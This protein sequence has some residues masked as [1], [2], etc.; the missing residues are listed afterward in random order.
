MSYTT[1][2]NKKRQKR[3]KYAWAAAM[4]GAYMSIVSLALLLIVI[5][6]YNE[7][8][9]VISYNIAYFVILMGF[10][11]FGLTVFAI[12]LEQSQKDDGL[13]ILR[14]RSGKLAFGIIV[15]AFL[16][17]AFARVEVHQ[18]QIN[19]GTR[20]SDGTIRSAK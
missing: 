14:Y 9:L 18:H 12:G 6:S 17:V 19:T 3:E 11:A 7:T 2:M 13:E 5:I 16:I 1:N 4:V 10:V 8:L 20:S 15:A